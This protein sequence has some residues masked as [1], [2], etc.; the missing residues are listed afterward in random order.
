MY[1]LYR[2]QWTYPIVISPHDPNIL[3]AAANVV[4]RSKNEGTSWEAIS[5]DLTRGDVTKMELSGGPITIDSTFVEQYGKIFTL[6]ES[7]HQ[8]GVFWTGSD[9]GLV[10]ISLDGGETWED[11][12]PKEIPE[13][14]RI[15]M[16]V[17]IVR[18]LPLM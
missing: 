4:F 14:T 13:W 15:D 18:M 6:A 9:D 1:R 16:I 5:P 3:Y 7:P 10:H 12:T 11:V 8:R 2:F 17:Y